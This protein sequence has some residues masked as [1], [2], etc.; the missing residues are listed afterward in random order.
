MKQSIRMAIILLA[1]N[2]VGLMIIATAMLSI[3]AVMLF[4]AFTHAI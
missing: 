2:L 1:F 4:A 3:A